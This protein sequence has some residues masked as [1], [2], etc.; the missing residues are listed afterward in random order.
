MNIYD[1]VSPETGKQSCYHDKHPNDKY[2]SSLNVPLSPLIFSLISFC[3]VW[4]GK[5]T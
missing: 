1:F 3:L 4:F 2:I 5:S